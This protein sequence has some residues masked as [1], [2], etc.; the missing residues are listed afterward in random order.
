MRPEE[1]HAAIR[2]LGSDDVRD[3]MKRFGIDVTQAQGVSTPQLKDLARKSGSGPGSAIM[4][5]KERSEPA[6]SPWSCAFGCR[7]KNSPGWSRSPSSWKD[8]RGHSE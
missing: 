6:T 3:S 7:G 8:E 4:I 2:S 5:R 1:V